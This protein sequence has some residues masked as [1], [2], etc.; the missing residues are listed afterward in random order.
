MIL[1]TQHLLVQVSRR[2]STYSTP[3][4]EYGWDKKTY[5]HK[6]LFCHRYLLKMTFRVNKITYSAAGVRDCFSGL[7]TGVV[8]CETEFTLSWLYILERNHDLIL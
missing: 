5:P 4:E 8:W 1:V 6:V 7:S 2:D 3:R